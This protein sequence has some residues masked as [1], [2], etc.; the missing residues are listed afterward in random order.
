MNSH[1]LSGSLSAQELNRLHDQ[2]LLQARTLRDAA[3]DEFWRGANAALWARLSS[4][5]RATTR[6]AHRLQRHQQ[7]R[8]G[9]APQ[10]SCPG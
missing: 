8:H 2:A 5:R 10:G 1:E 9:S 4:A 3:I 7:L 6:L